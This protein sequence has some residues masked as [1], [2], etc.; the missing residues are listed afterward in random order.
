[1]NKIRE[2]FEGFMDGWQ[3]MLAPSKYDIYYHGYLLGYK[4]RDKEI[5]NALEE[6]SDYWYRLWK[7]CNEVSN[8]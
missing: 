7:E 2:E 6:T 3:D 8:G 1:M 5:K 4:S